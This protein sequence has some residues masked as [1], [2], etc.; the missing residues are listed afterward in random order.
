MFLLYILYIYIYIYIYIHNWDEPEQAPQQGLGAEI[1]KI[2]VP[3]ILAIGVANKQPQWHI[4]YSH[5]GTL[6]QKNNNN[7]QPQWLRKFEVKM[8]H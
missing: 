2:H 7:N 5:K 4:K 6:A 8:E 3:S 1:A